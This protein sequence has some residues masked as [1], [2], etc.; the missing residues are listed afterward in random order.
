MLS[1]IFEGIKDPRQ[2]RKIRHK[3]IEIIVIDWC[4]LHMN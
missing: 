2:E 4:E 1:E 3:L